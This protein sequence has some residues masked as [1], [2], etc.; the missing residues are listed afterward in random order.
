[1]AQGLPRVAP[2][3]SAKPGHGQ[4][5][6]PPADVSVRGWPT[7]PL[8]AHRMAPARPRQHRRAAFMLHPTQ[9]THSGQARAEATPQALGSRLR[10][11]LANGHSS[12]SGAGPVAL[13]PAVSSGQPCVLELGT[14][15]DRI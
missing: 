10:G 3:V 14:L 9:R 6:C 2:W 7:A 5:S 8:T 12:P 13:T 15:E 4:A 1:M 11:P